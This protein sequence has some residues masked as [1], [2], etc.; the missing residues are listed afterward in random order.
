MP[1]KRA[2][3]YPPPLYWSK[4]IFF[5]PA[6]EALVTIPDSSNQLNVHKINLDQQL[7]LQSV[8]YFLP[9]SEPTITAT[10]GTTLRYPIRVKSKQTGT[11]F[12]VLDGPPV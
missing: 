12:Q 6:F 8:D 3:D 7:E 2:S 10:P 1:K 11:R 9:V 5:I 4:R